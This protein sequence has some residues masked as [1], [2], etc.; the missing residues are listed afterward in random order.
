MRPRALLVALAATVALVAAPTATADL[1]DETALAEKYAPV[2]RLVEQPEECGPGEPYI[3]T[4]VDVL[5]G[6]PTVALRGPWNAF[7]LVKIGPGADDLAGLYEYHLDFPGNALDPGCTYEL[8]ARRLT[9]GSEPV[10]YAH[11]VSEPAYAGKV[12]LQYWFFYPFNDFNNTHEGDWEMIQLVFDADDASA[13]LATEPT[14][15]GYSSHE[16]AERSDWTDEEKLD[17]VGTHPVVYPAAGSHANKFTEALYL[18]S[19]AEAGVGCDDT[20]GPHRELRPSVKTIP[21]DAA[22]AGE[23]FPWITFEGR[24]GE[25]QKAFYNGPTGPNLK[26]QWTT[27]IEWSEGWRD[28]SYAVPTAGLLGTDATDLFCSGVAAGSRALT[29]LVS[30]PLPMLLLIA[31]LLA[32]LAF[33]VI[34]VTWTPTA[35]HRI[36]RRRSF[37]Q[38]LSASARMY[39]K[40]PRLFL[41]IGLLMLPIGLVIA[42]LQWLVIQALD[43]VAAVT[44]EAAGIAAF[45]ALVIGTTLTLLALSFVM[46]ATA[47][48]LVE[49]DEGR[50]IDATNAFRL[51]AARLRPL[52]GATA[53]FVLVWV[54]LTA[55]AVLIPVALWLAIRWS[56]LAPVVELEG[57]TG[58]AALRRSA[59]LVR[60]RWFRVAG[61]V[62]V[63]AAVALTIGPL[64]GVLLIFATAA[65]LA[66]LNIVAGLVYAL[67][68]PFVALVTSYVYF[69]ARARHEL[70]WE[71]A[72]EELPAEFVLRPS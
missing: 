21:S 34:R 41:G 28:R 61:L 24:W 56:L 68:L 8:W 25:L 1:A 40:R 30:N 50:P 54:V 46:A 15:V 12:A 2:V 58:R 69:D 9:E 47:C 3:P 32:L 42:V 14:S 64:L 10:V 71:E 29:R 45:L 39:V 6:D 52:L 16:G 7:D 49:L 53:L 51:A 22:A 57:G 36:A 11:V 23:A 44:G 17:R 43:L 19:S 26:T 70:E 35:P 20:R 4:D 59:R 27:P 31:G 38:I 63:G 18:G 48:A 37:G 66:L 72:P 33:V 62:G 60:G 65:P 67:A 13:A 55:T 5:F